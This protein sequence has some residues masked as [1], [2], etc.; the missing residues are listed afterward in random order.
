MPRF[1][2]LELDGD[3]N[4]PR[5]NGRAATVADDPALPRNW[6]IAIAAQDNMK[7]H[8]AI[9][10]RAGTGC[11]LHRRVGRAGRDAHRAG[12]GSRGGALVAKG[13]G[14]FSWQRRSAGG[15]HASTV[16]A[17]RHATSRSRERRVAGC[18]GAFGT[19]LDGPG[20]MDAG[21]TA[22]ARAAL[23]RQGSTGRCRLAD[24]VGNTLIYD[25]Y[26]IPSRGLARARLA[27][28][29]APDQPYAWYVRGCLEMSLGMGG[30]AAA[31][32]GHCLSF[33]R[34]MSMPRSGWPRSGGAAG[35]FCRS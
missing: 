18:G 33:A 28:E 14:D 10:R 25:H 31:S 22:T 20:R 2:R 4:D 34:S 27:T 17:G 9:V 3:S 5:H 15:P 7:M 29:S 24:P 6:P 35:R 30:P 13:A 1:G 16:P 23:L 32:L 21:R 26:G 8:C 12:R 19:A 11:L